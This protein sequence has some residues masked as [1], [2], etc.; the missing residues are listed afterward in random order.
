MPSIIQLDRVS[1]VFYTGQGEVQA[2]REVSFKIEHGKIVAIIG[3]SGSG[4][5]TLLN[6]ISGLDRQSSGLVWVGGQVGYMFQKDHLL[7]WRS[8]FE[9]IRLGLEIQ[10]KVTPEAE[11]HIEAMLKKYDLWHFRDSY[12]SALSGGMRQRVALIRTLAIKPDILL[13]DEPFSALD[14][15]TR[16]NV[17]R[18]IYEMIR[19]EKKDAVL[20]THD[21]SEAIAMADHI[22]VLSQRPASVQNQYSIS[23]TTEGE[24]TPLSARNAPEFGMYFEVLWR[25]LN[26]SDGK[27][28]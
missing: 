4:K 14:Y 2:L 1:K 27:S 13:L 25:E 16:L 28:V 23:L 10:G 6:L 15:Q 21:I 9:N 3:P 17:S 18:D 19:E 7:E 22:I 24:R 20:V 26:A 5:S 11:K 8:I 12:P